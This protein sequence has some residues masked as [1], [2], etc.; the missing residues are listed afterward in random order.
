M[1][2]SRPKNKIITNEAELFY[3]NIFQNSMIGQIIVNEDLTVIAANKRMYQYVQAE[4]HKGEGLTFG[5]F[6][7]CVHINGQCTECGKSERCMECGIRNT[8]REILLHNKLTKEKVIQY[9]FYN[10]QNQVVKW[11]Q[12]NG[13][14]TFYDGH[15]AALEFTDVT[16]LKQQIKH[17]RQNLAIDFATGTLNKQSLIDAIQKLQEAGSAQNGFTICMIDFDDFKRI[18]DQFGHLMGDKVLKVFSE[19]SLKYVKQK[20]ILGRYGG[21]EFIFVFNDCDQ[22]QS[23]LILKRIHKELEE[24]FAAEEV[25][26]PVTFSAGAVYVELSSGNFPQYADLLDKVDKMLYHA[27]KLGKSRAM[28]NEGEVIFHRS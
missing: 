5:E 3:F 24:Y 10:G 8:A 18:N 6:F 20:D 4:P 15:Y 21:E 2:D 11:F 28:S 19:I 27:K 23:I 9:T 13:A 12:L 25:S 1:K 7:Q 22:E 16:E 14:Y 26:V 17:L